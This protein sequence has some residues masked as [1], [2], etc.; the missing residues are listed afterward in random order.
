[1]TDSLTQLAIE[2]TRII[3]PIIMFTGII[4]N[5]LNIAVLTR[6]ALYNHACSRYFLTVA[7][8]NLFFT[9]VMLLYRLFA[10]GYQLDVTKVS[11]LSCKLVSYFYQ[12][13]I[14]VSTYSIVHTTE[15]N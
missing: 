15:E 11:I 4:G 3:I 9:S 14:L 6:P 12:T 1:M 7:C 8:V 2:L 13:S 5:S 10:D